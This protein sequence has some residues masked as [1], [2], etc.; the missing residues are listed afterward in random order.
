MNGEKSAPPHAAG[1][2]LGHYR[3]MEKIGAGGM[4]EVYRARDEHLAR[5]VAIK[6]LPPG[7]L[8]DDSARKHFHKEAL[9]L[10]QLNH[11]NVATIYDF[12]T[13]R[14]V[15]F[16]VMEFIPGIILSEKVAAGPLPEK[17][18]L[19]LGVQLSEGLAAAHDHGVVHRD[20][21]PG[22]LR[23]TDD[24]RLKI[25]DFG[26]A[27]LR[28]PVTDNAATESLSEAPAMAGTLPYM[29][30][31]QL[32]GEAIDARTDI[33]AAGL[34]LYE[35]AT[36]R[37]PFAEIERSQL[38]G[39]IL[40]RPARPPTALNPRLSPELDRII[41]KCLEKEPENR[42]QSAKELR[43]DLERLSPPVPHVEPPPRAIARR[44]PLVMG[45]LL[46]GT[47]AA[48]VMWE[49]GRGTRTPVAQAAK[50]SAAVL[51]FKNLSADPE[52]EYFSDGVTEEIIT[53][54]SHIQGLA[55]AS[56][57]SVAQF[58]NTQKDIK[59]VGRELGVRYVLEGSVRKAGDRVR[60]TAQLIDSESG[61]HLWAEDFDRDLKDV[62]AVQDETALKIA[63]ALNLRL[64]P[65]EQQAVQRR[66]TDNP[67][68][69]DAYLRGQALI[70]YFSVPEKLEAARRHY[71]HALQSDPN[72]APAL[73][74]LASV[75][76][77]YY[78]NLDPTEERLRLAEQLAQRALA[79]DPELSPAHVALGEIHGMHYDYAQA[80]VEIHEGIRLR[81]DDPWAWDQL[82]WVLGYKQPPDAQGAE[83]A[84][85]EAIRLEP[86]FPGAF[87]HLGRALLEQKRY[88]E[89]LTAFER[90]L[91][92]S[93]DFEPGHG[94]LAQLYLAQGNYDRALSETRKLN[95]MR[96]S[97]VNLIVLTSIYS[98][99]GDRQKALT[100]LEKAL[101]LGYR[102][103]A[104]LDSSP[105][106]ASL[107][108]DPRYQQL[109]YRY[110]K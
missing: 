5:D 84:S 28:L 80:A 97:P 17:E 67:E 108:T 35:M 27:K 93:P 64:T 46:I 14:G 98:A 26:L 56:R 63:E 62:F 73:A 19:R 4:G 105:Y 81:S 87:Y 32:L 16:L 58:K 8:T 70:Q 79:L 6:V 18:V 74:G 57:T 31:E 22:N 104:A 13:Q 51:P 102:D 83:Q 15:D 34:V 61:F 44:W 99:S 38:I 106:L 68:A 85:R 11:P 20:L 89:A 65:Q 107:R 77:Q 110:R 92:L 42:Y 12:D 59:D 94:G 43:V 69:Y 82:S 33:H 3:V 101:H 39:A 47:V 53:K 1:E 7:T 50:P 76:A 45:L 88:G 75:E 40:H 36:G 103:F 52:N 90:A 86:N 48:I 91:E 9:I 21:K 25:L 66:Y 24:G 71:E 95:K 109:L 55:V 49:R 10:S 29:A 78:R 100:E 72:Y 60:I 41:G 37:Y 2:T 96:S 30:P 23:L 54:L